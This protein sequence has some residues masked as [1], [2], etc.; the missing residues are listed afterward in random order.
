MEFDPKYKPELCACA[1][2]TR[3]ALQ[4][5]E[6]DT[7]K[8]RLLAT[9]GHR[10]VVVPCGVDIGDTRGP[11][12]EA[13]LVAARKAAK[14]AKHPT[15]QV[16]CNGAVKAPV[17]GQ[18]FDRPNDRAFPPVD[19]V[20]PRDR[21]PTIALNAKY[22]KEIADAIGSSDGIVVLSLGDP[23]DPI[24]VW[25]TVGGSRGATPLDGARDAFAVLMPCRISK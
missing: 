12:P 9:D 6:L 3:V 4:H 1:D 22:L 7:E 15:A 18:S 25:G 24:V 14:K 13:A 19:E 10:L 16:V 20:I 8:K 17:A 5:V 23:E 11:I 21:K 2:E